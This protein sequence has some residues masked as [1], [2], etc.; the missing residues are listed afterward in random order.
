MTWSEAEHL[1]YPHAEQRAYA[2]VI[3]HY[4]GLTSAEAT[5]AALK[6]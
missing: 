4:G 5:E 6:C 3:R 1:D 2:R